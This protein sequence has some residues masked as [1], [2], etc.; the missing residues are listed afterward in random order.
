MV[1]DCRSIAK[2]WEEAAADTVK[3]NNLPQ[4]IL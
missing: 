2:A 3:Q 1:I 4:Q